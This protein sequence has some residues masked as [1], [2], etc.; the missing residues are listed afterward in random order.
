MAEDAI[1][2]RLAATEFMRWAC[3]DLVAGKEHLSLKIAH[4]HGERGTL[5]NVGYVTTKVSIHH[6]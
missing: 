6:R 4:K 3:A 2:H 1:S 5:F